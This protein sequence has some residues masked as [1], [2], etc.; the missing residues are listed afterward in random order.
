MSVLGTKKST[1]LNQSRHVLFSLIKTEMKTSIQA[2]QVPV[3]I[4]ASE[5]GGLSSKNELTD[6]PSSSSELIDIRDS[7]KLNDAARCINL[8]KRTHFHAL[9]SKR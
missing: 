3:P 1:S 9:A 5:T 2:K 7:D 4:P 8:K 6:N